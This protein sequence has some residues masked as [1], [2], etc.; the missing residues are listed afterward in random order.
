M[1]QC[2]C[3]IASSNRPTQRTALFRHMQAWVTGSSAHPPV[4]RIGVSRG[5]CCSR[6]IFSKIH[7]A[8][9]NR[10]KLASGT[11]FSELQWRCFSEAESGSRELSSSMP[12]MQT[13]VDHDRS[14][15]PLQQLLL[16]GARMTSIAHAAWSQFVREGQTVVDATCGNGHDTKWLAEK[17]GPTGRLFAFDIQVVSSSILSWFADTPLTLPCKPPCCA[18]PD[19]LLHQEDAIRSAK[20]VLEDDVR[21]ET[22]PSVE[23]VRGCHSTLKV[24]TPIPLALSLLQYYEP[25]P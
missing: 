18:R 14:A 7:S 13:Q 25:L 4:R 12:G 22:L 5:L 11:T 15:P 1:Q 8:W 19:G 17:I 23:F 16:D 2:V 21:H 6:F 20:A 24:P 10:S 9:P 3:R